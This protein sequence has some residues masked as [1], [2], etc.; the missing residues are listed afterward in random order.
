MSKLDNDGNLIWANKIT[1]FGLS[2]PPPVLDT[3]GNVYITSSFHGT[4]DFDQ[5]IGVSNLTSAGLDDIFILKLNQLNIFGRVYNDFNQNCILTTN[6]LGLINR[7]L[8]IQPGNIIVQTNSACVWHLDSLPAG[9]YIITADTSSPNWQITCPVTQT[10]TVIHPDSF[11]IAPAFGFISTSPC[12]SPDISI[13]APFLRPGFSNQNIYIRACNDFTGTGILDSAFVIVELDTLLTVL[14]GSQSYT[15]LGNN[16][17]R[18][19]LGSIYPGQCIDFT[20]SSHLSINT[21]LGQTL[22]MNATLYPLDSC[23][24]DDVPNPFPSTISPCNTAYDFS[25]LVVRPEC[26]NDTIRFV[27][28]NMGD[29]DMTCFSQVRLFIDG[30]LTMIDSVQ[31]AVGDTAVFAFAG[32]GRTWRLEVDQHPLHPGNSLPSATIELCGNASNWTSNLFNILPHNDAD[33]QID[34][35]CGLVTG[36][37]DSNDKTGYPLGIGNTHNI[38][39]NQEMEYVIRFQNTGTDTAFTVVIRDTLSMDLDIFSVQSGA[40]SHDYDFRMY[41]PRVL[42]WTFYNIMLPDS[43]VNAAAS[44]GFVKFNVQQKAD[45]TNGTRIE[46]SA[47]IY[48][49]FNAPIITNTSWHTIKNPLYNTVNIDKIAVENAVFKVYPNPNTG[50]LYLEQKNNLDI[51]ILVLDNLGRVLLTK[52]SNEAIT[53]LNISDLPAGIYYVN[54]NNGKTVRTEKVVKW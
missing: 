48:F 53:E 8:A 13:H 14:S 43:N 42:E 41:G 38:L 54:V 39:P 29:D 1:N 3:I 22:C 52:E 46:N 2:S 24:L 20:L 44:H 34:I 51:Q 23:A 11:T 7:N 32:D 35:Y 12:P 40:S 50:L 17:F 31:L 5:S 19:N 16:Q 21:I 49:D 25:D 6:E 45:L 37:F 33:P 47:A 4:I 10:F 27:I 36:S 30:V 26:D 18:I 15:A 9:T 28:T